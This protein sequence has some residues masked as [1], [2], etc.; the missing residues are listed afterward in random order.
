MRDSMRVNPLIELLFSI[1][2]MGWGWPAEEPV[3]VIVN[4]NAFSLNRQLN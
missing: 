2:G 4:R 3:V 1:D